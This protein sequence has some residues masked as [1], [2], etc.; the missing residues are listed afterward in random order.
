MRR[1]RIRPFCPPNFDCSGGARS[2]AQAMPSR[3]VSAAVPGTL[4][5]IGGAEDRV[6]R[7]SVLREFV[8]LAGGRGVR[9]AVVATASALGPEILDTY[10]ELFRD[11]GASDVV[12]LRPETRADAED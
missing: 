1:S 6:G 4:F 2:Y 3:A 9:V 11:L 8:R 5:V 7:R 12:R 10:E